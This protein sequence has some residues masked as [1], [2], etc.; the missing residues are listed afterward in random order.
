MMDG[1]LYEVSH[2]NNPIAVGETIVPGTNVSPTTVIDYVNRSC[3]SLGEYLWQE[4]NW[5]DANDVGAVSKQSNYTAQGEISTW[6]KFLNITL[7]NNTKREFALWIHDADCT[8]IVVVAI[9]S[10]SGGTTFTTVKILASNGFSNEDFC[11]K[12][13]NSTVSFYYCKR[14][15]SAT[16]P[17]M[18][19]QVLFNASTPSTLNS[20]ISSFFVSPATFVGP[21]PPSQAAFP[22][23][24]QDGAGNSIPSTYATKTEV[25]QAVSNIPITDLPPDHTITV[26]NS[27]GGW[28]HFLTY[29]PGGLGSSLGIA[30]LIQDDTSFYILTS[31]M[32]G[33]SGT[34]SFQI[35]G[36]GSGNNFICYDGDDPREYWN[37]KW[38]MN[39]PNDSVIKIWVLYC[40]DTVTDNQGNRIV[41]KPTGSSWESALQ[42]AQPSGFKPKPVTGFT[43][44][45]TITLSLSWSGS[46]PYT[47]TVTVSGTTITEKSS[48]TLQPT[49]TQLSQLITDGVTAITI[50]NNAGTLTAYALGGTP[51]TAMTI[52]C[53]VSEVIS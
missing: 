21:N 5:L 15:N 46:G 29:A 48:V 34:Y 8:A 2:S 45:G 19:T 25:S 39:I 28:Y 44:N 11:Y 7:S 3:D 6:Y 49:A 33:R 36:G 43:K 51:S 38:Y 30:L 12:T 40:N 50:E 20:D 18:K 27:S 9:E 42:S 26:D 1:T 22:Q 4:I 14:N 13:E 23:P 17:Y 10:S 16:N 35:L 31:K 32:S 41:R 24:M 37:T 53:T 47:Q 52:Q